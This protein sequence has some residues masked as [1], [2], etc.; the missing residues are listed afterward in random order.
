MKVA[1]GVPS[2]CCQRFLRLHEFN[3]LLQDITECK[4]DQNLHEMWGK[5]VTMQLK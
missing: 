2:E 4:Q 5:H 1:R 3:L